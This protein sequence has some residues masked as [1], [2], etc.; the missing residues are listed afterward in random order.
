[1]DIQ[2]GLVVFSKA[3]H[4]KGN[5]FAVLSVEG[6]MACIADGRRRRLEKPKQKKI[7]HLAVTNT[8]LSEEAL[9]T[10]NA[11]HKALFAKGFVKE[12]VNKTQTPK[13]G[14]ENG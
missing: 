13:G 1:M 4:D 9:E 10:N 7:R 3:G 6:N 11:L 12:E 5:W 8:L 14:Q 2:R